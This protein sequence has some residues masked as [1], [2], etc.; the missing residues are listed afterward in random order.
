VNDYIV[1]I[2]AKKA[3]IRGLACVTTR[4]ANEICQRHRATPPVSLALSHG[5]TAGIL[6]G[7]L[8]KVQQRVALK[9]EG[10]GFLRKMVIEADSYGRVRGYAI[11][12]DLTLPPAVDPA[13]ITA[14][15]GQIG[16]LTVVKDLLLKTPVEG[17]VPLQSGKLDADLVYYLMQS[18]QTPSLVEIDARLAPSSQSD[19]R[20]LIAASGGIL[21]QALPEHDPAVLKQ[22]ANRLEEM[23]DLGQLLLDGRSPEELLYDLMQDIQYDVLEA[24]AVRFECS[25]S[26]ERSE[27]A[28]ITLGR[29]ELESLLDEGEAIVDCYFCG[30]RYIFS[31]EVLETILDKLE[32]TE[33]D[34]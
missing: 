5:L 28:L 34:T 11:P 31:S 21:L 1:R 18:E 13:D 25:C 29:T 15:I 26:W 9:V 14:T 19:K 17:I 32:Q 33:Q 27:H 22:L 20:A 23:S 12:I 3:G 7:A 2:V 4:L 16:L 10:N 30:E 6:L 24:R 8:L